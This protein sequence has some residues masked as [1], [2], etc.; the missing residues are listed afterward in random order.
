MRTNSC[1]TSIKF[2]FAI[3]LHYNNLY[4][5]IEQFVK[6]FTQKQYINKN[7]F[8]TNITILRCACNLRL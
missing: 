1:N 5:K 2:L 4:N 7:V 6:K 3:C 8:I